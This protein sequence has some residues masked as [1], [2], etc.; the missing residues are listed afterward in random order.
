MLVKRYEC[1]R[2]SCQ[3]EIAQRDYSLRA[4]TL[5][6]DLPHPGF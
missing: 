4:E 3:T 2:I 6:N 1:F 5:L